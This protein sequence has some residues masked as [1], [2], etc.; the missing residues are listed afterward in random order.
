[1]YSIRFQ[2]YRLTNNETK[3]VTMFEMWIASLF[4]GS[5][6]G[7]V[8]LKGTMYRARFWRGRL[9]DAD[10]ATMNAYGLMAA[11]FDQTGF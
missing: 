5:H 7:F 4:T 11:H 10:T 3:G 2:Q 9:V 8:T 1:M 6:G